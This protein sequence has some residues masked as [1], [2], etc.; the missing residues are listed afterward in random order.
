MKRLILIF[1]SIILL[2]SACDTSE[3]SESSFLDQSQAESTVSNTLSDTSDA[4]S[5]ITANE[6]G[7]ESNENDLPVMLLGGPGPDA[8]TDESFDRFMFQNAEILDHFDQYF[9]YEPD[10]DFINKPKGTTFSGSYY[11]LEFDEAEYDG[12]QR[13]VDGKLLHIYAQRFPGNRGDTK[14][15]IDPDTGVPCGLYDLNQNPFNEN[16]LSEEE[17]LD[18]A[19]KFV[20]EHSAFNPDLSEYVSKVFWS[21]AIT[22]VYFE[23]Q[24]NG[25]C[26]DRLC[27]WLDTT[28][29]ILYFEDCEPNG[30][31]TAIPDYSADEYLE[32]SI[33]KFYDLL[34]GHY[35]E[36]GMLKPKVELKIGPVASLI[37]NP[38]YDLCAINVRLSCSVQYTEDV[39]LPDSCSTID[40]YF[41]FDP[42]DYE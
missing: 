9:L 25:V 13:K 28:G 2:F 7:T 26:V 30:F 35:E 38:D 29:K 31:I 15:Y 14:I 5:D 20:V 37:Y 10:P 6:S 12:L 33:K 8:T 41:P 21:T 22:E 36:I 4:I 19:K 42:D 23:K 11:G 34:D 18:I 40:F 27:L 32:A 1:T 24:I 3:V 16:F 17:F 39:D